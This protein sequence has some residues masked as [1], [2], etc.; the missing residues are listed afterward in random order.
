MPPFEG[1]MRESKLIQYI[2]NKTEKRDTVTGSKPAARWRKGETLEIP[3][4]QAN[5]LLQYPTV[6]REVKE[7]NGYLAEEVESETGQE[8]KSSISDTEIM[9]MDEPDIRAL[10]RDMKLGI[11][12][13][14]SDDVDKMKERV[15]R[16]LEAS[17]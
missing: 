11:R 13:Q 7:V 14:A 6:W 10:A 2:G 15:I 17:V 9:A 12:F 8:L 1:N 16:A 5:I 4:T 3:I